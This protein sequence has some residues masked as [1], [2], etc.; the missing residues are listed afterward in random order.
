[1]DKLRAGLR[2]QIDGRQEVFVVLRVDPETRL[3][4]LLGQ[5]TVRKIETGVPVDL[6]KPLPEAGLTDAN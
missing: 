3:A 1:M 4:D 6:L 5:G 2:V